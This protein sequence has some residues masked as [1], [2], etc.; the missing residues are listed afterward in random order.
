MHDKCMII[1][2]VCKSFNCQMHDKCMIIEVSKHPKKIFG[3]SLK[4]PGELFL[5]T[6]N[7]TVF[8]PYLLYLHLSLQIFQ[9]TAAPISCC[10]VKI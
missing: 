4:K 9:S 8:L 1:E 6:T 5:K 10:P 7:D 3:M 2:V